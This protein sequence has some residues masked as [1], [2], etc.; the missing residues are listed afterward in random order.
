MNNICKEL[1]SI[2]NKKAKIVLVKRRENENNFVSCEYKLGSGLDIINVN[3]KS[4]RVKVEHNEVT[5][6]I[7]QDNKTGRYYINDPVNKGQRLYADE[8]Y[9]E[10]DS[11][12]FSL[13]SGF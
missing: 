2:R 9:V 13:Y 12:L 7:S 3:N 10:C 4:I 5:K 1:H 8:K 6:K 11:K